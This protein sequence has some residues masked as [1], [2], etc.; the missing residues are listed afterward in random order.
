M[1]SRHWH[2]SLARFVGNTVARAARG[3]THLF[4]RHTG[5]RAAAHAAAQLAPIV[6]VRTA[7]G[8]LRFSCMSAVSAKRAL[9]FLAHEPDTRGWLDAHIRRGDHVWDVGANLGAY[10]LY[11][12]LTDGVT[13]TAFEPVPATFAILV[14]NIQ[15]NRLTTRVTPIAMA[16]SNRHAIAPLYLTSREAGSAMHALGS[17][18]NV[19][20][21]FEAVEAL[22]V[23]AARGDALAA[24]FGLAVPDHIKID[25]DGH[26]LR[27]LEGISELLPHV[28]TIWIEMTDR[29]DKSGENARICHYLEQLG[30]GCEAVVREGRNRLFVNR[31]RGATQPSA[32]A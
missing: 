3:F 18:E 29:A 28:R 1:A 10:T 8:A 5:T 23:A 22:Q 24:Q 17:P 6:T 16:L 11:A 7:K 12:C 21:H 32:A 25:V 31:L 13:V 9:K 2:F 26:E 19:N 20:G 14:R 15:L 4:G 27:V 30:Y